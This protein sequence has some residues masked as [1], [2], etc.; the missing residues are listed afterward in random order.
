MTFAEIAIY[1]SESSEP[2]CGYYLPE[3]LKETNR[4]YS[5]MPL[6]VG[7][8]SLIATSAIAEK[9]NLKEEK[10][11]N[12]VREYSGNVPVTSGQFIDT[13]VEADT[14]YISGRVAYFDS[15][16]NK[17][18]PVEFAS[19]I[20][21]GTNYG[22]VSDTLGNFKLAYYANVSTK[23]H[24]RINAVGLMSYDVM[25]IELK[26]KKEIELGAIKMEQ[27]ELTE[28]YVTVK[29]RSIFSRFWKKITQSFR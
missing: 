25:D 17:M 19:I 8:S 16:A 4:F 20:V 13:V 9:I 23:I 11:E 14:F 24:L 12:C 6:V 10:V 15:A 3:Q 21:K 28:F 27:V 7:F 5:K 26:D 18:M 1:M 22:V 2:V 29:K